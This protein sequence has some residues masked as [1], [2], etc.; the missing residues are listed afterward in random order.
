MSEATFDD[1][2]DDV[3]AHG[4]QVGIALVNVCVVCSLA[5]VL[6]CSLGNQDK[7]ARI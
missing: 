2:M 3:R 7:T 6:C 1:D 4:A 5:V